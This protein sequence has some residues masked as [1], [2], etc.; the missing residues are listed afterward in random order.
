MLHT[1]A[2]MA[3]HKKIDMRLGGEKE[4]MHNSEIILCNSQ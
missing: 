2:A 1:V 3:N 4:E